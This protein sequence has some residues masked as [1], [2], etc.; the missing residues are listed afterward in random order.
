MILRAWT[1]ILLAA[2][3]FARAAAALN[4]ES[5]QDAFTRAIHQLNEEARRAKESSQFPRSVAN[6]A[7]DFQGDPPLALISQKIIA[8]LDKDPLIDAYIRWQLTSFKPSLQSISLNDRQFAKMLKDL[9]PLVANPRTDPQL[10]ETFQRAQAAEALAPKQIEQLNHA[11]NDLAKRGS[12]AQALNIAALGLRAWLGTQ[13]PKAGER[14]LLWRLE[15]LEARIAAGWP[16]EESKAALEKELDRSA[17]DRDFDPAARHRIADALAKLQGRQTMYV[18]N[19]FIRE[20]QFFANYGLVA[21]HDF[22]VRR[23]VKMLERNDA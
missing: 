9:P 4:S 22:D 23:W 13:L 14:V 19:A 12:E 8:P 6:F 7:K 11:L 1:F 2:C 10:I 16:I 15:E 3:G 18:S 20:N 17:R 5:P 21:V